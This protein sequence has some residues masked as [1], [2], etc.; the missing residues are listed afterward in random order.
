LSPFDKVFK[1]PFCGITRDAM[2]DTRVIQAFHLSKSYGATRALDD[3]SMEV[4]EGEFFGFLG[5]NGAGKT[6]TIK[7]LT[8]Q[9]HPDEGE[10]SVMGIDITDHITI[11]SAVGIVPEVVLLPSFLT[12][13]E[14]LEFVCRVRSMEPDSIDFWLD[15]TELREK[16]DTLCKDL[17]QGMK[18]KLSFAAAFIH[19]PKLVFL[20]EPFA[21]VDPLMQNTLKTFLKEYTRKG[22]TIFL[23]TH[24]LE[25]AEKLC[26]RIAII[27]KGSIVKTGTTASLLEQGKDLEDVFIQL[28]RD[29]V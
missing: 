18:Q 10:A 5:P 21:D 1:R 9:L 17:S 8:G 27:T 14:Y 25:I 24:I 26:S 2:T 7:V 3:L 11:K 22:G 29:H 15:F 28:V 20:D 16:K 13:E 19:Q 12:V 23:S 6:T 4:E